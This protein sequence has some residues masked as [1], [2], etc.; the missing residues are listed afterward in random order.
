M[1]KIVIGTRGSLLALWQANF[2]KDSL[3]AKYPHMNVELQIVK[4]KGDKI[5]DT[6]LSK[7]GGKGLFTKEL[8][9]LLLNGEIDLAVHSLKDV[10]VEF[11]SNLGLGAITK[12]ED[13]RDSFLSFKYKDIMELPSG[14]KVG[15]TSLRRIMQ[16]HCLRKDIDCISLRGNVQTRLKRLKDGDFD[17][18]ILAQAGVNRLNITEVPIIKQLDFIP[19]MG[20][21]ALG[22]E[23]RLDSQVLHLLDFL[24]DRNSL[25]ET[26]AER[27]FIREL[28]GGC[29]VPI[30]VNAKLNEHNMYIEAILGLPNG[31][32][33]IKHN[34]SDIVLNLQDSE[35]LGSKLAQYFITKGANDILKLAQNW[36]F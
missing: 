33:I 31:N 1:N 15:T 18:I 25:F 8:E 5:L 4:T 16:I 3:I 32:K 11:E 7:I 29:Q 20:Q 10:P 34:M 23:C 21:A 24:N 27:A 30:G 26:S 17:A 22:I 12:R 36:T 2:I 6:P 35:S 14:A 19:A 13:I 28:N 9:V